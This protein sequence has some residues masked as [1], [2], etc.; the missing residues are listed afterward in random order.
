M[1]LADVSAS[2]YLFPTANPR[3]NLPTQH[4]SVLECYT[5]QEI[6]PTPIDNELQHDLYRVMFTSSNAPG[7]VCL[8][9]ILHADWSSLANC[10]LQDGREM[11]MKELFVD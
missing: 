9:G 4:A 8:A 2:H 1:S 10:D 7:W 11:D 5:R 6:S 3:S